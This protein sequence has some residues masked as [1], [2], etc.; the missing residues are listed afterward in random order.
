M[1]AFYINLDKRTDRR[2]EMEDALACLGI[3]AER[4][5]AIEATPGS[6]GCTR[7][8]LEVLKRARA[9]GQPYVLVLEDDFQALV[10]PAQFN[11][12]LA[13]LLDEQ[14]EFDLVMLSYNMQHSAPHND[15]LVKVL[16]AGT[17]SGYIVHQRFYDTLIQLFEYSSTMLAAHPDLPHLYA[18]DVVWRPIQPT[19]AWYAFTPRLGKQRASYSD[20]N[21]RMEDYDV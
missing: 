18:L 10:P 13:R 6:L 20:I 9:E 16:F 19:C 7:S 3:V 21:H 8:H 11:Q 17:A 15:F 5:P 1:R 2:A 12:A 14:P 4:F